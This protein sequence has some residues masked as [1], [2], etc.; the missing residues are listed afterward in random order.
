MIYFDNA[1]TTMV[2]NDVLNAMIPYLS[3]KFGNPSTLYSLGYDANKAI[4]NS[5]IKFAKAFNC[6][7]NQIFFTSICLHFKNNNIPLQRSPDKET[8]N[9][10]NS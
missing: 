4:E 10:D 9:E 2:D 3:S 1:A 6:L 5:R 8:T 7:P